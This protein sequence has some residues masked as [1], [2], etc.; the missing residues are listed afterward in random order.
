VCGS[1]VKFTAAMT[2]IIS[3]V[4]KVGVAGYEK[5]MNTIAKYVTFDFVKIP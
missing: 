1:L 3:R 5:S 4:A 2:N